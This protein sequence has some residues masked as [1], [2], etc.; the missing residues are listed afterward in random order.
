M[1][2]LI[3]V[4][5]VAASFS[6]QASFYQEN[7]SNGAATIKL[8][9]GHVQNGIIL[10]ERSYGNGGVNSQEIEYKR[11]SLQIDSLNELEIS[12]DTT[13]SCQPGSTGGMVSWTKVTTKDVVIKKADGSMF[14]D[15]TLG[16]NSNRMEVKATVICELNGNSRT[17]CPQ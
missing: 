7:C 4:A 12:A 11:G 9:N 10:T 16:L 1:K 6:A 17:S 3:L 14:P 13:T 5:I 15:T 8:N 2:K